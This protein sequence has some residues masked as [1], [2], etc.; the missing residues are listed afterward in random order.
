MVE[1]RIGGVDAAI[2]ELGHPAK[3]WFRGH[4]K[5]HHLV[6][7]LFRFQGVAEK[8]Y[9]IFSRFQSR[10]RDQRRGKQS[11]GLAALIA[12]HEGYVPNRLLA[13]TERLHVALFCALIRESDEPT[14]FVLDPVALNRVSNVLGVLTYGSRALDDLGVSSWPRGTALPNSPLAVDPRSGANG[15]LETYTL[16]GKNSLPLEQ[17]CPHCVCKVVLTDEERHSAVTSIVCGDWH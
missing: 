15:A 5:E 10:S 13:W 4:G 6:P 1:P 7:S 11:S 9:R 3:V 8:E 2:A 14:V 12:M 17:Q 16:H